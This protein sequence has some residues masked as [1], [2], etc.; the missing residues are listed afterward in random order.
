MSKLS[1]N[2]GCKNKDQDFKKALKDPDFLNAFIDLDN[3]FP[4]AEIDD[5]LNNYVNSLKIKQS[6]FSFVYTFL[7]LAFIVLTVFITQKIELSNII[8]IF[9]LIPFF[10]LLL[11]RAVKGAR[12]E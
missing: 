3:E 10:L 12:Y 1:N 11:K 5:S 7:A 8:Q 6:V 4:G 2:S 9:F